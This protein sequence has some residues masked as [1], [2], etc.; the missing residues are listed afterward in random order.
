MIKKKTLPILILILVSIGAVIFA[1][2]F[3][4]LLDVDS[5]TIAE[6]TASTLR[7]GIPSGIALIV[8]IWFGA[9]IDSLLARI[10]KRSTRILVSLGVYI[11]LPATLC[12]GL[13]ALL[14]SLFTLAAFPEGGYNA[15]FGMGL[16]MT[17]AAIPAV[18][19]FLFIYVG[20]GANFLSRKLADRLWPEPETE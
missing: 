3:L 9:G 7:L 4:W 16:M 17:L 20:A 13:P 11:V 5:P 1:L 8:L 12:I 19:G 14:I 18:M 2:G 10:K 15:S 6:Q